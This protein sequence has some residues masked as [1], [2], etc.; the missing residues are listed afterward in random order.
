[1]RKTQQVNHQLL[2]PLKIK[3]RGVISV[4]TYTISLE[5]YFNSVQILWVAKGKVKSFDME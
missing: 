3:G 2:N 5:V 1:M 4:H